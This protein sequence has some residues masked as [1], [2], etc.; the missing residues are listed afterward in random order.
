MDA[1]WHARPHRRATRTVRVPAW[2][3]GDMSIFIFT[4]I[5]MLMVHISIQ[6]F[7]FKLTAII[8]SPYIPESLSSFSPC[9]TMFPLFFLSQDA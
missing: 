1:T 8:H 5:S 6:Y 4:R 9:G 7:G 3:G 2:H